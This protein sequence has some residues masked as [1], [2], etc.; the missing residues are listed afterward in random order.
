[1][2]VLIQ[3]QKKSNEFKFEFLSILFLPFELDI[4]HHSFI[5]SFIHSQTIL[6]PII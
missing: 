6:T 2:T 1:M 4:N 3:I 5:H